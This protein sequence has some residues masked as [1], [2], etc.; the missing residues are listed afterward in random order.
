MVDIFVSPR[1]TRSYVHKQI[2]CARVP[3]FQKMFCGSFFESKQNPATLPKED[4]VVFDLFL[5]WVYGKGRLE[6]LD[7]SKVTPE[8]GPF[9]DRIKLYG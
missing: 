5:E 3:Y 1:K 2:L 4:P 7:I 6:P 8:A 9:I